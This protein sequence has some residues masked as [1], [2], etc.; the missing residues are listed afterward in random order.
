MPSIQEL[1]NEIANSEFGIL[2]LKSYNYS[3]GQMTLMQ[4]M[5]LK[6]CVIAAKVPSLVDYIQDE[7]NAVLYEPENAVQLA[8]K[9]IMINENKDLRCKI[10]TNA[11]KYI[12]YECNEVTMAKQIEKFIEEK[13]NRSVK[14]N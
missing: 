2:P 11:R 3:Y 4:Q 10:G 5:A 7:Y 14:Y 8:L 12:E 1:V 6:K 9:I 13:M